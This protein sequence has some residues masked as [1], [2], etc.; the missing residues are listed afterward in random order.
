MQEEDQARRALC[1][2][3]MGYSLVDVAD[4]VLVAA[5]LHTVAGHM[6]HMA[7]RGQHAT[8]EL[9]VVDERLEETGPVGMPGCSLELGVAVHVD[10]DGGLLH[11][12]LVQVGVSRAWTQ[13]H[14]SEKRHAAVQ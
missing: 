12:E 2:G 5:Q 6:D 11:L 13:Q 7:C 14:V 1:R 8:V 9:V 3:P 4:S 10:Q